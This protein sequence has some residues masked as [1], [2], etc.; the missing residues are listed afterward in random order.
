MRSHESIKTPRRTIVRKEVQH[1]QDI[2]STSSNALEPALCFSTSLTDLVSQLDTTVLL[3][4]LTEIAA[5]ANI[6]CCLSARI[7][8][9]PTYT[10][11][12]DSSLEF[13]A[14]VYNCPIPDNHKIY[15]DCK[16]SI[17]SVGDI[18]EHLSTIVTS[19]ICKGV[20]E[21]CESRSVAIDPNVDITA[22]GPRTIVAHSVPQN[23]NGT[24]CQRTKRDYKI[25]F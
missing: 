10:V 9:V 15:N 8:A 5:D 21:D 19:K 16:L 4:W 7:H 1:A 3:P 12:V 18:R 25:D 20:G 23:A 14:Y 17:N 2:P 24:I 13:A 6:K 22:F 11:I